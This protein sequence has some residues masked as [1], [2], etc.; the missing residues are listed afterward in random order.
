MRD[1]LGA[2]LYPLHPEVR[3]RP[4]LNSLWQ[5]EQPRFTTILS[6]RTRV[7]G[8]LIAF[9]SIPIIWDYFQNAVAVEQ[10]PTK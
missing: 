1:D 3:Q 5:R 9:I 4:M 6:H 8:A 2:D 10:Q 7:R